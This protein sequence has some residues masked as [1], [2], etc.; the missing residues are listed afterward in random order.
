M[1]KLKSSL[2]NCYGR[3]HDLVN[4]Y[5]IS[6]SQ[7]IKDMHRLSLS[8]SGPFLIQIRCTSIS[9]SYNNLFALPNILTWTTAHPTEGEK[10]RGTCYMR[11]NHDQW[12]LASSWKNKGYLFH[13]KTRH[14]YGRIFVDSYFHKIIIQVILLIIALLQS[15]RN[16]TK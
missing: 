8:L 14:G 11:Q 13:T 10:V 3:H 16:G 4:R 1:A 12:L 5:G 9:R 7:L 2:P 6:V 15:V